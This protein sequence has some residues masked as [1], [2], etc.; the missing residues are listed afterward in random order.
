MVVVVFFSVRLISSAR[1]VAMV[2]ML[3]RVVPLMFVALPDFVVLRAV[4]M[5]PILFERAEF[6][7]GQ[8]LLVDVDDEQ[9]SVVAV[10]VVVAEQELA[11]AVRV[12]VVVER[13]LVAAVVVIVVVERVLAAVVATVV[14]VRVL[15]DGEQGF[16]AVLAAAVDSVRAVDEPALVLWLLQ[17]GFGAL[18]LLVAGPVQ[19]CSVPEESVADAILVVSLLEAPALAIQISKYW[20]S[21]EPPMF[22]A[23]E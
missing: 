11:V 18:M 3:E 5:V 16:A 23:Y 7:V 20:M 9:G 19:L 15:D 2:V 22:V 14:V 17:V 13:M 6:V 4:L 21:V 1:Q 10:V 8:M 12:F